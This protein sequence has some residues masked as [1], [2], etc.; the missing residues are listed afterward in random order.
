M[1]VL[2]VKWRTDKRGCLSFAYETL[3]LEFGEYRDVGG[4]RLPHEV[5]YYEGDR[6]LAIDRVES[7]SVT[8]ANQAGPADAAVASS[9]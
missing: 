7:I 3:I 2:K 9:K 8:V 6:L 5:R 1:V 4:F